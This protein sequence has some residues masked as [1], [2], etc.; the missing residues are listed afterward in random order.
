MEEGNVSYIALF[1]MDPIAFLV[2]T[3]VT[4]PLIGRQVM[5]TAFDRSIDR[6]NNILD[7][8]HHG[9]A[10]GRLTT[11]ITVFHMENGQVITKM[12][13]V[14][15]IMMYYDVS[16]ETLQFKAKLQISSKGYGCTEALISVTLS[17]WTKKKKKVTPKHAAFWGYL[18][19]CIRHH[20]SRRVW[21]KLI[22]TSSVIGLLL[23]CVI[24]NWA[25]SFLANNVD[26]CTL[27]SQPQTADGQS[28][29]PA[30]E[31]S[32]GISS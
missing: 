14:G 22:R 13:S 30:G 1:Y 12:F 31:Y 9:I 25:G 29:R 15:F 17:F 2:K 24:W 28:C 18:T 20:F 26:N 27:P 16:K 3:D 23:I 11:T 7:P 32:G 8:R 19:C 21:K 10:R 6:S 4:L 5:I